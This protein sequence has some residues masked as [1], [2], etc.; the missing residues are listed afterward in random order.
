MVFGSQELEPESLFRL[1]LKKLIGA[2][3]EE[4]VKAAIMDLEDALR[5]ILEKR[6][7]EWQALLAEKGRGAPSYPAD[8]KGFASELAREVAEAVDARIDAKTA[9][10]MRSAPPS[11]SVPPDLQTRLDALQEQ[12]EHL[13]EIV[14]GELRPDV[15]AALAKEAR[16][17]IAQQMEGE[18]EL[19]RLIVEV[20][21]EIKNE[22]TKELKTGAIEE[23]KAAVKEEIKKELL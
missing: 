10:K 7:K 22:V 13:R 4:E 3:G 12:L 23:I 19:S 18:D 2:T 8:L 9:E 5:L 11:V 14:K 6:D 17:A 15:R 1:A 21:K 16:S 20:V